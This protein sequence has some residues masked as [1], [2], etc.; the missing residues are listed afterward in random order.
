MSKAPIT[1]TIEK[2]VGIPLRRRHVPPLSAYSRAL[3]SMDVG[4]SFS[5]PNDHKVRVTAAIAVGRKGGRLTGKFSMR[6]VGGGTYR[7]WRT[8]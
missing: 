1:I 4:D 3:M 5:L 6:D 8:A 2:N 7:V